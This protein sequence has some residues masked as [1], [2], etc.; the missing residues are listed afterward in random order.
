MDS[1]CPQDL[2][3]NPLLN[4]EGT[5]SS[6]D[7]VLPHPTKSAKDQDSTTSTALK[8]NED[9]MSRLS[10]TLRKNSFMESKVEFLEKW[11]R[12][13]ANKNI[14]LQDQFLELK[15]KY[16]KAIANSSEMSQNLKSRSQDIQKLENHLKV[17]TFNTKKAEVNQTGFEKG[18]GATLEDSSSYKVDKKRE[19][20]NKI[21][22]KKAIVDSPAE[23]TSNLEQESHQNHTKAI[24]EEK[25]KVLKLKHQLK[26]KIKPVRSSL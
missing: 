3:E 1:Y 10:V 15:E 25:Q 5:D 20:S 9:L 22:I 18:K 19:N 8:E 21:S 7:P 13:L 14:F 24:E 2:P 11:N 4:Q 23:T 17:L 6:I 12:Q 26:R 16:Q